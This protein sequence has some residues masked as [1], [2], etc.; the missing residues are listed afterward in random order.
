MAHVIL[1]SDL[2]LS[3]THGFFWDNWCIARD[4]LNAAPPELVI[5][6]GD[7][8]INGPASDTEMDFAGYA[9]RGLHAP[10]RALPGNHDVV[11]ERPAQDAK[12]LIDAPRLAR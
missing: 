12:Q 1:I 11:D 7:L 10:V 5:V 3:P 2:H 4:A 9:L 6:N 8:C